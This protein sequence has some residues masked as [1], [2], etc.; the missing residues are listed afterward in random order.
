MAGNF[1]SSTSDKGQ[2]ESTHTLVLT[3]KAQKL[4]LFIFKILIT[5]LVLDVLNYN[6]GTQLLI[7]KNNNKG[8]FLFTFP[9]PSSNG[10]SVWVNSPWAQ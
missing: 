3:V 1:L 6:S 10:T 8:M 4:A 2:G 5:N 9:H 7:K